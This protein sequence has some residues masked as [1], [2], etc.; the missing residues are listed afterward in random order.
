MAAPVTMSSLTMPTATDAPPGPFAAALIDPS[1]PRALRVLD[2][3]VE[4]LAE[5]RATGR[6]QP[7]AARASAPT[8]LAL[9]AA[10]AWEQQ[11]QA[12]GVASSLVTHAFATC[13][14]EIWLWVEGDRRWQQLA[15][16]LAE[17]VLRRS[18]RSGF[19]NSERAKSVA[20]GEGAFVV[21]VPGDEVAS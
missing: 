12:L 4:L 19:P 14:R 20:P 3:P 11:L 21:G 17:R 2:E 8:L 16:H 5:L 13:R 10:E 18:E 6:E 7:A 9:H 15:T 1:A